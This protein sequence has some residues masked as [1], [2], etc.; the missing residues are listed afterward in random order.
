MASID[1]LIKVRKEKLEALRSLGV[2]PYPASVRRDHSVA[3]ARDMEKQSVAVAGRIM[4][5]RG[6]GKLSF[7]DIADE[8]GKIQVMLKADS[9]QPDSFA[10]LPYI[11]IGDIVAVQGVIGNTQA[12]ELSVLAEDFQVLTKTLRPLPD[13]W[14]GLKDVEERYRK[15]YLDTILNPEVKR[16]LELRSRTIDSIRDFLTDHGFIEVETPTLQPV[17]GGGFARPFSTHHNELDADLYLRISDEMYLKRLIVG[18]FE[19]VFEITK[20]FRN[21]GIDYDHNPE[22][23]MFEAQI[24]YEDYSYGMDII[25]E[26]IEYTAKRV[27]GETRIRYQGQELEFAR[28]WTRMKVPEAVE[29]YTGVN[30]LSWKTLKEAK[31]AI[32]A[33][34]IPKE[35]YGDLEKIQSIGECIAFVFEQTVEEKLIQPTIIYD[36]P[37][38]VSPLAKKCSDP[39]FTQRFE[40]FAN[41][42]ELGNNYSELNDPIDLNKRF[43]EEKKREK[44]GFEEAH[45]TDDDYLTAIEHG[46]PPTC[47]IA[48][49]IDRLVM[50]LTDAKNIKEVIP[51]PT[52]RPEAKTKKD[53]DVPIETSKDIGISSIDAQ[54]LLDT[55]IKDPVTKLHSIESE[56][57]M[58]ELARYFKENEEQWGSLGLL[59]DIDWELTKTDTK[60]HCIRC[61]DIL[62]KAGGSQYLIETIQSHGYGQGFGDEYYGPPEFK[63]KMRS[64]RVQHALAAAETLTGLIVASVL[65]L[66]DKKLASLRVESLKKKFKNQKFAANCRRDIILECEQI[67]LTIDEFLTLGLKALQGI[68]DK[69]GL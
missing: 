51:F 65:V 55:Y 21:E 49:G 56:A 58:R 46:F 53:M 14:H 4:A 30:P 12:G 11:D 68:S 47:G 2:D 29:K 44:A 41:G 16:R 27:L 64:G 32:H 1:E 63:G 66:P 31:T 22:F 48:I 10:L 61:V 24:A 38:E 20:V 43:V 5:I 7:W 34:D 50:F 54:K 62:K 9:M 17:Y 52:L 40:M 19:K 36:Y 67:G 25:E 39:R 57:I 18:G 59:H 45:Q 69:L 8:S 28:P 13:A 33:M 23:T 15:R 6:H 35:K 26:I 3:Q 60:K 37:I 42:S